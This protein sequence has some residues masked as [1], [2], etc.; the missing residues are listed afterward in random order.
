MHPSTVSRVLSPATRDMVSPELTA[1]VRKAV[2]EMGYR[3][4]PFAYSLKTNRSFT[5]GVLIPDLTNPLFPP[6]IRAIEHTLGKAGY[7]AMVADANENPVTEQTILERMKARQIDGLILATA[8]RDDNR[9]KECLDE[10]ISIVLINRAIDNNDNN[11]FVVDD[12]KGIRL[13]VDHVVGL[14]HTRIAHIAGPQD[15]STAHGRYQGF[16]KAMR[17]HGL[18]PDP[19]LIF[20][21]DDFSEAAGCL[22]TNSLLDAHA[23]I[24]A[25]ITATDLLA[26]GCYDAL[27]ERGILCPKGISVVGFNDMPFVD[28]FNPPLTTIR[29]P[30]A[31]MGRLAA[32]ALLDSMQ[33]ESDIIESVMLAPELIIRGSTASARPQ[34]H[35]SP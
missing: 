10:G 2:D 6:I 3:A 27:D 15:T 31:E 11:S 29:I 34:V 7:I 33:N 5:V 23:G 1:K 30:L 16:M 12:I 22:A 9:V 24:T 28:K 13:A 32:T 25:F 4:N 8:H 19:A 14:G 26:L 35:N 17:A 20:Y 18:E 21:C